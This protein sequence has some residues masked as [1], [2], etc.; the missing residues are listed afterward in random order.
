LVFE[1]SLTR[2]V[3]SALAKLDEAAHIYNEELGDAVQAAETLARALERVPG[4]TGLLVRMVESLVAVGETERALAEIG[5][6]IEAAPEGVRAPLLRIR[7]GLR[8]RE[9]P[10][11]TDALEAAVQDL[12][13]AVALGSSESL[14]VRG[15]LSLVLDHLRGL[16]HSVGDDMGERAVVLRQ[17]SLLPK[18]DDSFEVLETLASWL[19]EHP[20]DTTVAVRLGE[21]ATAADDHGTAAFAYARLLDASEGDARREAVLKFADAAENAGTAMVARSALEAVQ[22][23]NPADDTLRQRLRQMYEVAGAYAELGEILHDQ[24]QQATE[25]DER[26]RLFCEAGE[27][28]LKA[29]VGAAACEIFQQALQIRPDAY[30]VV[31]QLADAYLAQ[32]DVDSAARVLEQA[33]DAHGKRR[34]PELSVLQ[35]GLARVARMRGDENGVINWLE[36]SLLND[37]QNGHAASD[38]A[39]FA[40]ERG[41]YETAI[42]ALQLIT[43]LKTPAP[44]G[45]AEAYLRQAIIANQQGDQKK[46]VL[47]ARRATAADPEF[48]EA[49]GFLQ[50]LG[51]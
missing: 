17:A 36:A 4:D 25:P 37:R 21:L 31:A 22:R 5:K 49:H 38:L 6:A 24:A 33:V 12:Q 27:L 9:F 15:E 18:L 2:D 3:A 32:G 40:Q 45:R 44:M 26:F 35:H 10:Q 14:E 42:K 39:I 48:A 8:V 29:E 30:S 41:M 16:Y 28:F 13:E 50:E 20:L 11:S 1:A 47:L 34:T 46:A 7:G 51:G 43:L 23:E 19:R